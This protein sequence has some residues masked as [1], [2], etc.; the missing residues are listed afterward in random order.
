VREKGKKTEWGTIVSHGRRP[1]TGLA[2][3]EHVANAIDFLLSDAAPHI[4]GET[5]RGL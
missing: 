1:R 2:A 3:P 4:T 5:F